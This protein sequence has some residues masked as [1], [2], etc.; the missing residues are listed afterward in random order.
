MMN[1]TRWTSA[2]T[3]AAVIIA[4]TSSAAQVVGT[5]DL[6]AAAAYH[7]G[8]AALDGQRN[9]DATAEFRRSYE[10]RPSPD[11]LYNLAVALERSGHAAAAIG[12]LERYLETALS[13]T[14]AERL[15][16]VRQ[17]LSRLHPGVGRILLEVRPVGA[18]VTIDGQPIIES[19][20]G[21]LGGVLS[22]D[23]TDHS[24]RVDRGRHTVAASLI[25]Y[26]LTQP[27]VVILERNATESVQLVLEREPVPVAR[28]IPSGGI[29]RQWWFWT[30]IG[31]AVA[32][33][34]A[35]IIA[36]QTSGPADWP[37]GLDATVKAIRW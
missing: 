7:R 1:H 14:P 32:G 27:W 2:L 3:S 20:T 28:P 6:A 30:L 23:S 25:G 18:T 26:R 22:V 9:E 37:S 10:L 24:I 17:L 21:E 29:A 31:V 13:D 8:M 33:A 16:T 36:W 34:T 5:Q 12:V 11:V 19:R 15:D 35:G 4:T